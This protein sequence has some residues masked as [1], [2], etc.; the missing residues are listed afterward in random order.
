MLLTYTSTQ[1]GADAPFV[2]KPVGV[3]IN[4]GQFNAEN[5]FG[6]QGAPNAK[7]YGDVSDLSL[8]GKYATLF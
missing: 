7:G 3:R 5:Y 6:F 8:G 1:N 2:P 4:Y